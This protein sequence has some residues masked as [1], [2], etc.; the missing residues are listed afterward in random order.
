MDA[1]LDK[2]YH[3]KDGNPIKAKDGHE[4]TNQEVLDMWAKGVILLYVDIGLGF[5][6][7][8]MGRS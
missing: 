3:D 5:Q 2:V 4:M 6:L 1:E 7:M 8:P